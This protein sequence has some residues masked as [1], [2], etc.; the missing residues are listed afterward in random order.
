MIKAAAE[1]NALDERQAVFE[2][3]TAIHRAGADF[4]ITYYAKEV[5]TWLSITR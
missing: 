4:I 5:A 3:L 2:I 1:K